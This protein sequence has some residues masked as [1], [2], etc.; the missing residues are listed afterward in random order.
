MGFSDRLKLLFY[1]FKGIIGLNC[2]KLLELL[3]S[4]QVYLDTFG[5]LECN[6]RHYRGAV[7]RSGH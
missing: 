1:V 3:L 2:Q 4:D 7:R 5:I 6:L